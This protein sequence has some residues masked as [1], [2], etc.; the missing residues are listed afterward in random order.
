M[1]DESCYYL[2]LLSVDLMSLEQHADFKLLISGYPV[3]SIETF[4]DL[5]DST[6]QEFFATSPSLLFQ[7]RV[8]SRIFLCRPNWIASTRMPVCM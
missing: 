5:S 3:S 8:A 1:K 2:G 4:L 6:A 7:L